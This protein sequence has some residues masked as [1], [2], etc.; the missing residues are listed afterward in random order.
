[1]GGGVR[2]GV[3]RPHGEGLYALLAPR[4]AAAGP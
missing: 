1:M 3:Y 4:Y 2:P